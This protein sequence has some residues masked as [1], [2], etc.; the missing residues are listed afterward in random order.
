MTLQ[1]LIYVTSIL[2]DKQLPNSI[3]SIAPNSL[4]PQLQK[5][6]TMKLHNPMTHK[7]P[8]SPISLTPHPQLLLKIWSLSEVEDHPCLASLPSHNGIEAEHISL[9]TICLSHPN[10]RA[11]SG[12]RKLRVLIEIPLPQVTEHADQLLHS[13]A[14]QPGNA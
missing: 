10:I 3:G 7:L 1:Q 8:K 5:S 9:W 11:F 6:K 4:S 2:Y 12:N 14:S 13:E